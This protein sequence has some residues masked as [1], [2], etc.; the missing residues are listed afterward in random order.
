MSRFCVFS[1]AF[2]D[3]KYSFMTV[4]S[5]TASKI[6]RL[7]KYGSWTFENTS[8]V[9]QLVMYMK[10]GFEPRIPQ[11]KYFMPKLKKYIQN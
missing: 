4:D 5:S 2:L 8:S 6:H 7:L 10:Q 11:V 9:F 1:V 3:W